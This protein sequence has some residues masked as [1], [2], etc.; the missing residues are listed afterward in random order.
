[1]HQI[2]GQMATLNHSHVFVKYNNLFHDIPINNSV[3]VDG[4]VEDIGAVADHK[5]TSGLQVVLS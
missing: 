4:V 3:R 5:L 1:M 2:I